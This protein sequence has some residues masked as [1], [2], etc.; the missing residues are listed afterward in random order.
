MNIGLLV[1]NI[2][3]DFSNGIS[4]GAVRAAEKYNVNLIAI[5]GK[6]ID[7]ETG[8]DY[9]RR[10]E[11]QYNTL[12][13][14]ASRQSLD[15][16]V[17]CIGSIGY[18]A[19]QEHKKEFLEIFEGT[20]V[21]TI[22]SKEPA[23]PA[24]MFDNR[25]GLRDALDYIVHKRGK[26]KIGLLNGFLSNDD[27]RE[28]YDTIREYLDENH[29]TLTENQ[30]VFSTLTD[31]CDEQAE[32]LLAKTPDVEAIICSND[33]MCIA[34]Y[35]V[36]KKHHLIPGT[37]VLVL[38][39]DDIPASKSMEPSLATINADAS[40]LGYEAVKEAVEYQKKGVWRETLVKTGFVPRES[41]GFFYADEEDKMRRF[42][43]DLDFDSDMR[44]AAEKVLEYLF[45]WNNDDQID[46]KKKQEILQFLYLF[47][48]TLSDQRVDDR[49]T[50]EL[51]RIFKQMIYKGSFYEVD[52]RKFSSILETSYYHAI[53]K[54]H[55][56]DEKGLIV[57]LLFHIDHK[58]EDYLNNLI[59]ENQNTNHYLNHITNIIT[60]DILMFNF[61]AETSYANLMTNL[62]MLKI[63][64][65]YLYI[66]ENPITHVR[67]DRWTL[68]KT[69]L[70][71]AYQ[72][73][74]E[75]YTVPRT[76]QRM[77]IKNM[78]RNDYC[79]D[80]SPQCYVLIDLYVA[81]VQYGVFLCAI[82]CIYYHYVELLTYQISTAIQTIQMFQQQKE[83]QH[84]LEE[85]MEQLQM[86]NVRLDSIA[87][88]DELTGTLNR[89]GF[90]R[91]V[92]KMM[93]DEEHKG[94]YLVTIYADLDYLKLINDQYGHDEGDYAIKSGAAILGRSMGG[95]G[96][97]GQIGGD[98]FAAFS[99]YP[100]S[101][102]ESEIREKIDFFTKE[103]NQNN[104][105]PY[106]VH[107]SVGI[108]ETK[109]TGELFLKDL[110]D[111][112]DDCLYQEKKKKLP[113]VKKNIND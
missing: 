22:A 12:F 60:R 71:K 18:M 51:Y 58:M 6:Y 94:K 61:D 109:Y 82:P 25:S 110:L 29:I 42:I 38:G 44:I 80:A 30:I 87:K 66:F 79:N 7:Q 4:K 33:A 91:Q 74:G 59:L 93:E 8:L 101:G 32:E 73:W 81:D 77:L 50:V 85:S 64:K 57:R 16:L 15:A 14:Y 53:E 3:D 92:E 99:V 97:F 17:V 75:V 95:I 2:E 24:I 1:G 19:S 98:E 111:Q 67:D 46:G 88:L 86:Y 105:K 107:L 26:T 34:L 100:D 28:R 103:L 20:P 47:F 69:I 63:A 62:Q 54:S 104:D 96:T 112:A 45:M 90:Y 72:D 83:M 65:S 37:D 113:F 55:L 10:Y 49:K 9:L 56:K 13:S 23:Y 84:K 108:S 35:R 40:K 102:H 70:L 48:D 78:F 31:E 21:I 36:L 5:L 52:T 76:K 68:P 41:V 11:Y 43:M 27:A 106:Y 89:R 39:F